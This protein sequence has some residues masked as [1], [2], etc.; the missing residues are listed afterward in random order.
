LGAKD[1]T[2]KSALKKVLSFSAGTM[3]E[4]F[5]ASAA[6]EGDKDGSRRVSLGAK[7]ASFKVNLAEVHE[8]T[9]KPQ[10]KE[11]EGPQPLKKSASFRANVAE[12]VADGTDQIATKVAAAEE[13]ERAEK[14]IMAAQ[15]A[16]VDGEDEDEAVEAL[17][18]VRRAQKYDQAIKDARKLT[19]GTV[20]EENKK[21]RSLS[22]PDR[23]KRGNSNLNLFTK[24]EAEK[25]AGKMGTDSALKKKNSW[26]KE[27][28]ATISS[29]TG[30]KLTAAQ[31]KAKDRRAKYKRFASGPA[32]INNVTATGV[33]QQLDDALSQMV[34]DMDEEQTITM[35]MKQQKG[36]VTDAFI[37]NAM[38]S[39]HLER[40][41]PIVKEGNIDQQIA[42]KYGLG[43]AVIDANKE[44]LMRRASYKQHAS[45]TKV[46]QSG[47][48]WV[49]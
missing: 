24:A 26:K 21:S 46:Y 48:A 7:R 49:G 25:G 9:D 35:F 18:I 43:K 23:V 47:P 11:D 19:S 1:R 40:Q 16:T 33:N 38:D 30:E 31:Q 8:A 20:V 5:N 10:E 28:K 13:A 6:G 34:A 17:D 2:S 22:A 27:E 32:R 41:D 45:T 29:V 4:G 15:G 37:E 36:K 14:R 3:P 39:A 12:V 44:A 42:S